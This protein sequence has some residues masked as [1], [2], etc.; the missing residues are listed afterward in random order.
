MAIWL[1]AVLT[2]ACFAQDGSGVRSPYVYGPDDD[3]TSLDGIFIPRVGV[4][5]GRDFK[6]QATRA[7]GF[8][9][10]SNQ[11]ALFSASAMAGVQLYDHFRILGSFEGDFASKISAEVG[12]AYLGWHQRP[13]ER[14]GKGVPDEVTVYAGVQVGRIK[15]HEDDFGDFDR[16]VGF[17]GGMSFGWVVSSRVSVDLLA[18]YRSLKFDYRKEVTSGSTSIGGNTGWFGFGLDVRF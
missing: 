5:A 13:K 9:S 14:Y 15:V 2:T 8:T 7:D 17:A 12:G 3:A 11:Q 18:E 4:W 16:G 1:A 6:F 10:T